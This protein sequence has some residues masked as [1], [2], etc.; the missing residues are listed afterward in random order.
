MIQGNSL[1]G[2]KW[3]AGKCN[4]GYGP[5]RNEYTGNRTTPDFSVCMLQD[6]HKIRI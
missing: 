4:K 2:I 6:N 1:R 3:S 5:R